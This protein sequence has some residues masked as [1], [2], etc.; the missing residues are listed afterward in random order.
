MAANHLPLLICLPIS[1]LS[2][3]PR[4]GDMFGTSL[5]KLNLP[6]AILLLV[7]VL[8][9]VS[10]REGSTGHIATNMGMDS[11]CHLMLPG[12]YQ[13]HIT[14]NKTIAAPPQPRWIWASTAMLWSCCGCGDGK[15]PPPPNNQRDPTFGGALLAILV[16]GSSPLKRGWA[17][18]LDHFLAPKGGWQLHLCNARTPIQQ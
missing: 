13:H 3:W 10:D 4:Q 7:I 5:Y 12:E 17:P 15:P 14:V 6:V 18:V 16:P 11:P 2:L 8:G 9:T 1:V